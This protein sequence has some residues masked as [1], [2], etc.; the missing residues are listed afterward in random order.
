MR[1]NAS[2][3]ALAHSIVPSLQARIQSAT[4]CWVTLTK[5][6]ARGAPAVTDGDGRGS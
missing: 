1:R 2:F 4:R 5:P 6:V 3:T